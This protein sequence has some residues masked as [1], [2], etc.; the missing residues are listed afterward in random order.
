MATQRD[1]DIEGNAGFTV[2]FIHCDQLAGT[3][4]P[5]PDPSSPIDNS[6]WS[7]V[8]TVKT[9]FK[10]RTLVSLSVG[11]GIALGG[12]NGQFICTLT[13]DQTAAMA[14]GVYDLLGAPAAGVPVRV[15]EGRIHFS[16]GVSEISG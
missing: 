15:A 2:T 11:A 13:A 1:L 6:G 9:Q 8:L 10:G 5:Q 14:E 4:P 16:P 3:T 12:A 7:A